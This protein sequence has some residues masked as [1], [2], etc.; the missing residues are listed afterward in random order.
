MKTIFSFP[1]LDYDESRF[2]QKDKKVFSALVLAEIMRVFPWLTPGGTESSF[3]A[4][5]E[6]EN[7]LRELPSVVDVADLA[8]EYCRSYN[9]FLGTSL[10]LQ[11]SI[12]DNARIMP[13]PSYMNDLQ[14]LFQKEAR[15][16][17][18]LRFLANKTENAKG[19]VLKKVLDI[20]ASERGETN[21]TTAEAT[22]AAF[23]KMR[24]NCQNAIRDR[25]EV[26]DTTY[27]DARQFVF[28]HIWGGKMGMNRGVGAMTPRIMMQSTYDLP[29]AALFFGN[30]LLWNE[31]SQEF[32][33]IGRTKIH[34]LDVRRLMRYDIVRNFV[35][36]FMDSPEDR[37]LI[38][39]MVER[40]SLQDF[41]KAG[42]WQFYKYGN[43]KDHFSLDD[44]VDAV[45]R[46]RI[47]YGDKIDPTAFLQSFFKGEATFLATYLLSCHPLVSF[48]AEIAKSIKLF[49]IDSIFPNMRP[50]PQGYEGDIL[51]FSY[52][53]FCR[54]LAQ[55]IFIFFPLMATVFDFL[56]HLRQ[57]LDAPK[58]DE[59]LPS[60]SI[61][62]GKE[63]FPEEPQPIEDTAVKRDGKA[64]AAQD[65]FACDVSKH[66]YEILQEVEADGESSYSQKLRDR[67]IYPADDVL[68]EVDHFIYSNFRK[69]Y[70]IY[71]IASKNNDSMISR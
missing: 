70:G 66:F 18:L 63:K 57:L 17:L 62:K 13:V 49:P 45:E 11:D 50:R 16:W 35:N 14:D 10:A 26:E 9:F 36:P 60:F 52:G 69:L 46:S 40:V 58:L 39:Y 37:A 64:L 65:N 22:S 2:P 33:L 67:K 23:T 3:D 71:E 19:M 68:K 4:F 56:V 15:E 5:C 8:L 32:F 27:I 6:I 28:Q 55:Q 30:K 21:N 53:Y 7:T 42:E 20:R 61:L 12:P 38:S 44:V 41:F 34:P 29:L 25:L 47:N 24:M 59:N 51:P 54:T 48:R 1:S 43:N 31:E